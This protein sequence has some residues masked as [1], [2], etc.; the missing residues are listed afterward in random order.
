MAAISLLLTVMS[1]FTYWLVIPMLVL[2]PLAFLLG[3]KSYRT[4]TA[5]SLS[6]SLSKLISLFPMVAA[7][8]AFLFEFYVM[9][10]LYR[11]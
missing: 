2:P 5:K 4:V 9:N 11:P 6:T 10:M 7:V 3:L 1:L 8:M